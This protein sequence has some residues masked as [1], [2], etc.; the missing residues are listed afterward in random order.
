LIV[1]CPPHTRTRVGGRARVARVGVAYLVFHVGHDV[2]RVC[3]GLAHA[4]GLPHRRRGVSG[5][6]WN[7]KA[8]FETG[9]SLH[10]LKG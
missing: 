10:R 3:G 4:R 7:S 9:F 6:S 8:H 2:V 5:T 1:F